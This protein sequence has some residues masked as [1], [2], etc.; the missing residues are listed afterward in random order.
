M[1]NSYNFNRTIKKLKMFSVIVVALVVVS[2]VFGM[3]LIEAERM[4]ASDELDLQL[5][6]AFRLIEEE[7][8]IQKTFLQNASLTDA[9]SD[10]VSKKGDL[11]SQEELSRAYSM[12]KNLSTKGASYI[13][14]KDSGVCIDSNGAVWNYK[15]AYDN[16]WNL[17]VNGEKYHSDLALGQIFMRAHADG[18]E[19]TY[20]FD[21]L[22]AGKS[23]ELVYIKPLFINTE[24]MADVALIVC[25]DLD[26]LLSES[27]LLEYTDD[28]SISANGVEAY[29]TADEN[30]PAMDYT[31]T[32]DYS[33]LGV[34]VSYEFPG[35][36]LL[37]RTSTGFALGALFF[38]AFLVFGFFITIV[39][40]IQENK[41][42]K[43][44]LSL[45]GEIA[46]NGY[47]SA[48]DMYNH[49]EYIY[50][51]V[52]GRL[53]G[54]EANV[55][56]LILVKMLAFKLTDEELCTI[57]S[58]INLPCVM[59]LVKNYSA[60]HS[61]W[62]PSLD[63]YLE[64]SGV[65]VFQRI[66]VSDD[67][68]VLFTDPSSIPALSD[69]PVRVN[70]KCRADIRCV[71][72]RLLDLENVA[73]VYNKM[74]QSIRY[75][76]YGSITSVDDSANASSSAVRD[77]TAKSRHLYELIRSANAFE[78]KRIVYE[79]WYKIGCGELGAEG[80]EPLFYSQ[81]SIISQV[82]AEF[83]LSVKPPRFDA[84]KDIVSL[85]FEVA[86]SI[87]QLVDKLKP[88]G[89]KSSSVKANQIVEYINERYTDSA[90]YMPELV[91]RFE[92]SDRA[93]V[94]ILKLS[95]GKNFSDY[96]GELR[97]KRA[98]ELLAG[99]DMPVAEI[100]SSSGFDSSNSL[101]KAFKKMY[102][103]SPSAYRQTE[104]KKLN[105]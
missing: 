61:R 22:T 83:K 41:H 101:Y 62:K 23:Y 57:Q 9:F 37:S 28:F 103:I 89:K 12:A 98:K 3:W 92:M 44:V 16:T 4:R 49:I 58:S 53:S 87:D 85:A 70:K 27:N 65:S 1:K 14:F 95:I 54:Y 26:T 76:E 59:L 68:T 50:K 72:S 45:T 29:T 33:P 105:D 82:S 19:G 7:I 56:N 52:S 73:A 31:H 24:D 79:Q 30:A 20:R 81:S 102:G 99:T 84:D 74:K 47:E 80:I 25:C 21:D 39:S 5:N 42:I 75:L 38:L 13:F 86:E 96:V 90:F 48:G 97:V 2:A 34:R 100:A 63:E 88:K 91:A 6:S 67:E 43:K 35:K 94:R 8:N 66:D 17:W 11:K 46:D 60:K 51:G 77:I 32:F 15:P 69:M 78:A 40:S 104:S 10:M 55:R 93:I 18:F 71:Y 36:Y 64:E